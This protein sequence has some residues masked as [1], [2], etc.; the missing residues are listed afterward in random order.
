MRTIDEI[1]L[2]RN[3]RGEIVVDDT[4]ALM[5]S[6]TFNELLVYDTTLPTGTTIG[7]RWSR[8]EYV[9][10]TDSDPPKRFKVFGPGPDVETRVLMG[11]Y[12]EHPDPKKVGIK[13]REVLIV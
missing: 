6:D 1:A 13:F 7:K 2:S 3:P 9:A 5:S 12:V 10:M 4:H 8:T 11:E